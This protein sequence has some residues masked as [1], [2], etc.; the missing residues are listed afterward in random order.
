MKFTSEQPVLWFNN[1]YKFKE[2]QQ[3]FENAFE[4]ELRQLK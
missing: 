3:L 2:V 4:I 1:D